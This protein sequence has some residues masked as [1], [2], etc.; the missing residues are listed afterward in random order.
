M[1]T[2]TLGKANKLNREIQEFYEALNCFEYQSEGLTTGIS[3]NPRL[4]IEFDG[5]DD[6]EHLTLPMNLSET[7]TDYLKSEI[8][9][10]LKKAVDEFN[11]L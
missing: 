6:R 5:G 3:T 9:K 7:L 1:D 8:K 4:I 11:A 10:G 2:T